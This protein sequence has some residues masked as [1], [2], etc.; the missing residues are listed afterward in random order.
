MKSGSSWGERFKRGAQGDCQ[1]RTGG[2]EAVI[3]RKTVCKTHHS[4]R[5]C[6]TVVQ[7]RE[8][9]GKK[10]EG[11]SWKAVSVQKEGGQEGKCVL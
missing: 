4:Q 8:S 1:K 7:R 9:C 6:S 11:E 10:E 2:E 5:H 3:E